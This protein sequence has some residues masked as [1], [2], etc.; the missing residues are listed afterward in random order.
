[1]YG[2]WLIIV[3]FWIGVA[4]LLIAVAVL[5]SPL[6]ALGIAVVA[7]VAFLLFA[8]MGRTREGATR[9][10]PTEAPRHQTKRG[11]APVSGEGGS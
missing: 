10:A 6:I 5:A 1:M 9:R 2:R 3:S 11:G 4:A 8:G 7:G